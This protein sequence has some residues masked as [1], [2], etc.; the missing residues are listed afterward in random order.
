MKKLLLFFLS[1]LMFASIGTTAQ[2]FVPAN[3][4]DALM[5]CSA[6]GMAN[7]S[8]SSSSPRGSSSGSNSAQMIVRGDFE[9]KGAEYGFSLKFY[10][11]PSTGR[12]T[13]VYYAPKATG[14][15]SKVQGEWYISSDRIYIN[16]KTA[17]GVKTEIDA[18]IQDGGMLGS[19]RRGSHYG[20]CYFYM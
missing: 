20:S 19:M 14:K 12:I 18:Y 13:S 3:V 2:N 4:A 9:Y 7:G 11:N 8:I 15:Y 16:G 17:D 6:A 5:V 1:L 10:Y